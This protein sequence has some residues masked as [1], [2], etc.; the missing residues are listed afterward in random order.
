MDLPMRLRLL[1]STKTTSILTDGVI[2]GIVIAVGFVVIIS[3]ILIIVFLCLMFKKQRNKFQ[4]LY[5]VNKTQKHEL[6]QLNG[7]VEKG[8]CYNN[9]NHLPTV[10]R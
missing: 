5:G 9:V 3:I 8:K 2:A 6:E 10:L 4:S 7:R 1:P